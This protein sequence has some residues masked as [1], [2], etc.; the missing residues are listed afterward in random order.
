METGATMAV[1]VRVVGVIGAGV[2]G[3]AIAAH[4]AGA[5]VRVHLLDIV[6]ADAQAGG[7][8]SRNQL[9][10]TGLKRALEAKPAAF[11]EAAASSLVQV[12][13]LEDDVARLAEC[14]LVIEAVVENLA[15]KKKLFQHIA[16]HLNTQCVLASNTSGLSVV[17]MNDALPEVL[18]PR[19]LVLHFFNPVRYMRLLEV[20]PGPS[21][22]SSVVE[23]MVAFGE[24]LGKGIVYG[25]DTTNFVANRI[26]VYSMMLSLHQMLAR[27]MSIEEVDAVTGKALGRPKSATFGTSD[28]VGIDTMVH[29][30]K[31]C[32][33]SLAGDPERDVF[34]MPQFVHD[35]V[36][37]GALG[38]KSGA[39]F[40]KKV[41]KDIQVLNLEGAQISPTSPYRPQVTPSHASLG[42]A[43]K[44]RGAAERIK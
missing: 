24:W 4:L 41:G 40:Y 3:S 1:G 28:L 31:N 22:D 17:E 39:G 8:S 30:A 19:F 9:A 37:Q 5:G 26:G 21:T 15:I 20:V 18:R 23:R 29:V 12:G 34:V 35:L 10:A 33:D 36:K 11:S 13:N 38:R 27:D 2:M 14:D 43:S 32:Y 16:P 6:P 25:K 44:A 42:V 7:N